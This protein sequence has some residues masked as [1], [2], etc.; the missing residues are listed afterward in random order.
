MSTSNEQRQVDESDRRYMRKHGYAAWQAWLEAGRPAPKPP[1]PN[2]RVSGALTIT[3]EQYRAAQRD[4]TC[5]V[6]AGHRSRWSRFTWGRCPEC[7]A[8]YCRRCWRRVYTHRTL[9]LS[10]RHAAET[11]FACQYCGYLETKRY[12][13]FWA[14]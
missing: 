11:T 8:A 10:L 13:T 14:G 3:E 9:W 7:D 1:A 5:V 2:P 4:D 12:P 6:C